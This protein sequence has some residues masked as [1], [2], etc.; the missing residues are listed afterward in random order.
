[1]IV[2]DSG[3]P[4]LMKIITSVTKRIKNYNSSGKPLN[5]KALKE[6]LNKD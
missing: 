2:N 3:I 1:M 5:M 4:D 6:S